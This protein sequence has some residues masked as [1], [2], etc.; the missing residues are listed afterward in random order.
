[1]KVSPFEKVANYL[2]LGVFGLVILGPISVIVTL[3]FGPENASVA[4]EGRVF[5]WENFPRRGRSPGSGS[6]C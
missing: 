1:M 2:I 4:Q 5:H 3:A 6:T